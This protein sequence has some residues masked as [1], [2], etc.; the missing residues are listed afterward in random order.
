[1]KKTL[2]FVL[3]FLTLISAF[4]IT[5]FAYENEEKSDTVSGFL[6]EFRQI[7]PPESEVSLGEEELMEKR[8]KLRAYFLFSYGYG[9]CGFMRR[10]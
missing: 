9:I 7:I 2:F 1:M 3:V 4:S 8:G 6:E 10:L 5:A